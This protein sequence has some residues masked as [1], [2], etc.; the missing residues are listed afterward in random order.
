MPRRIAFLACAGL[1]ALLTTGCSGLRVIESDVRASAPATPPEPAAIA[2]GAHYRFERLP[3]QVEAPAQADAIEAIAETELKAAG[4]VRDDAQARYS[5]QVS[6]SV[7]AFYVDDWGR[8]YDSMP[9]YGL[10]FYGEFGV[11]FGPGRMGW[12]MGG[13]P[14]TLRYRYEVSLL[15]REIAGSRIVYET[16][17]THEGPW[18]DRKNVLPA[19]M[20]AALKDFPASHVGPVKIKIPR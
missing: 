3:S 12:G 15:I 17:A 1:L 4:L 20:T 10:G 8:R 18:G 13:W 16:R 6:D 19:L 14:P 11:H 9:P 2:P 7:Q 5:V